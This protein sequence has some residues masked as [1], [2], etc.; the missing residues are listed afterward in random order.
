MKEC[1]SRGCCNPVVWV[2]EPEVFCDECQ[3]KMVEDYEEFLLDE[4]SSAG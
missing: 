3:K 4:Q 1:E 2:D